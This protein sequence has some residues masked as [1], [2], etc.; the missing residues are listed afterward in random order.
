[1]TLSRGNLQL[2]VSGERL[3]ENRPA[4]HHHR[5]Q[6]ALN[7]HEGTSLQVAVCSEA[8][9]PGQ[10]SNK[11]RYRTDKTNRTLQAFKIQKTVATSDSV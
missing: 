7:H 9:L 11:A 1:M 3:V 2:P 10:A 6:Q 4:V 8:L 5:L